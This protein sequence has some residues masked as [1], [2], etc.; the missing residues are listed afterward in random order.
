MQRL[1]LEKEGVFKTII[2]DDDKCLRGYKVVGFESL[3]GESVDVTDEA[4]PVEAKVT[5]PK[6]E[7]KVTKPA[8]TKTK[9][10]EVAKEVADEDE[11][12]DDAPTMTVDDIK[13]FIKEN[14][15]ECDKNMD[16]VRKMYKVITGK[17]GVKLNDLT[18]SQLTKVVPYIQKNW[19]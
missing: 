14:Q 9:A 1:I 5:K 11:D 15:V 12:E 7:A 6:P 8:V 19:Q 17:D 13:A 18:A 10:V 4:K 3:S 16:D 2:V